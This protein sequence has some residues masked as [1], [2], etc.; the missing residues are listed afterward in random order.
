MKCASC[1]N[2]APEGASYCPECGVALAVEPA[3]TEA[4]AAPAPTAEPAATEAPAA[5]AVGDPAEPIES[6]ADGSAPAAESAAGA[7]VTEAPAPQAEL[8]SAP[9]PVEA[10]AAAASAPEPTAA[11]VPAAEPA[12]APV[13][14]Y[15]QP[16]QPT[17]QAAS[18]NQTNQTNQNPYAQ[19]TQSATS[20]NAWA[21][22][23]QAANPYAQPQQPYGR[24]QGAPVGGNPGAA[25]GQV[26]YTEGCISAA[27]ADIRG[28][29]NWFGSALVL[30]LINC[31]P[32]LN[33]FSQGY[34]LNWSREVPF[35][36]KTQMPKKYFSGKNF[37]I[38]FYFFLIS[39]VFALVVGIASAVIGWI[40]LIGW[41]AALAL[42][43]G[44]SMFVQ[45]CSM[46]MAMMQ[47]LGDGFSIGKVW[48]MIKRNWTG[49]FCAAVVP[50]IV[51]GLVISVI[52][53]IAMFLGLGAVVPVAM[54]DPYSYG[55]SAAAGMFGA[56]G[57]VGV[58][59]MLAIMVL[60][61]VVE[62]FASLVTIRAVAHW[63]GRYAP[64]WASEAT[65]R[66]TGYGAAPRS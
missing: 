18:T 37:E 30:G 4:A 7:P 53:L 50:G 40:P 58:F 65:Y 51:A 54:M 20:T 31:V 28:S 19:P 16:A 34:L 12:A 2:V 38:G 24:P 56:L 41:F 62:F 47:Q 5:E 45:A 9:Q 66:A 22:S 52:A 1:G 26:Y 23:Q 35:G 8:A 48:Q 49:L 25:C 44:A 21:A 3:A 63:V 46:R 55:S 43:F 29:K 11:A 13:N 42:S 14:P 27:L 32:V 17:S 59:A 36:G 61:L 33:F 15:A 6:A 39:L 57:V 64:E 10:P 60:C